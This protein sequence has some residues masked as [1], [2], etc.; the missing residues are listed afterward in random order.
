MPNE[1]WHD[2]NDPGFFYKPK[3]EQQ[4]PKKP[5]T[6]IEPDSEK[7]NEPPSPEVSFVSGQFEP[8]PTYG[9]ALNSEAVMSGNVRLL[10]AKT[11]F[12]KLTLDLFAIYENSE[13]NLGIDQQKYGTA[14]INDD[15]T[16]KFSGAPLCCHSKYEYNANK[17]FV[18]P[19]R[20][21]AVITNG[22]Q[23]KPLEIFLD[24][25][26]SDAKKPVDL[27]EGMYD[28]KAHNAKPG[29]YPADVS[30][31]YVAGTSIYDMQLTLEDYRYLPKGTANG[32]FGPKTDEAVKQFQA[33]SLKKLRVDRIGGK[34]VET[35]SITYKGQ[36]D[37]IVGAM[38]RDELEQWK[39]QNYF[40]GRI[41]N[42]WPSI[43]L[44]SVYNRCGC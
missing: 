9:Y 22:R 19:V 44:F 41:P 10:V 27:K 37:G 34:L 6:G 11:T 33:D 31:G 25:P 38:T 18:K 35:P 29:K 13:E 36:S 2:I 24:L 8:H 32:V 20:Y 16:F 14:Y 39:G 5:N 42:L 3:P 17:E 1:K 15:L 21:K 7:P 12:K 40:R 26:V 23:D 28:D 30:Q 43:D 4:G